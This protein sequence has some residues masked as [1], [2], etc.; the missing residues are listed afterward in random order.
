MAPLHWYKKIKVARRLPPNPPPTQPFSFKFSDT[1][2][3]ERSHYLARILCTEV[4]QLQIDQLLVGRSDLM[5]LCEMF[6]HT[7]DL[8]HRLLYGHPP[9]Q[10]ISAE[11]LVGS[12]L[13]FEFRQHLIRR[14]L[15]YGIERLFADINVSYASPDFP[16]AHHPQVYRQSKR[17]LQEAMALI[18]QGRD[19]ILCPHCNLEGHHYYVC[20]HAPTNVA[21]QVP[22]VPNS[23]ISSPDIKPVRPPSP[24]P[25]EVDLSEP[26]DDLPPLIEICKNCG[27]PIKDGMRTCPHTAVNSDIDSPG[28]PPASRSSS[29][30]YHPLTDEQLEQRAMEREFDRKYWAEEEPESD[31]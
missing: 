30:E 17:D 15:D 9:G 11:H 18:N 7:I 21:V 29:P 28:L 13:N 26:D 6:W 24:Y 5:I 4:F 20:P 12:H 25:P 31:D 22:T 1:P 3:N 8:D 2:H 10:Q 27:E 23:P 14:M 16:P 19:P